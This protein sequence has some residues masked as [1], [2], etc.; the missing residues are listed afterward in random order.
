MIIITTFLNSENWDKFGSNWL[1]KTKSLIVKHKDQ[2]LKCL[3]LTNSLEKDAQQKID[4]LGFESISYN[5]KHKDDRDILSVLVENLKPNDYCQF[6]KP[7]FSQIDLLPRNSDFNF[8]ETQKTNVY[9][10]VSPIQNLKNRV[11]AIERLKVFEGNFIN[12]NSIVGSRDFW[13][14]YNGFVNLIHDKKYVDY[15]ESTLFLNLFVALT[16]SFTKA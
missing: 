4:E 8:S 11:K 14:A 9:E 6:V 2:D 7:N 10:F 12:T 5:Q 13:I 15:H 1:R 16:P 3:V